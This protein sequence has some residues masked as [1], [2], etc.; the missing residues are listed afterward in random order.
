MLG[1]GREAVNLAVVVRFS[2]SRLG[3]F[4]VERENIYGL[5]SLIYDT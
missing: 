2:V 1:C 5:R 4:K 3:R